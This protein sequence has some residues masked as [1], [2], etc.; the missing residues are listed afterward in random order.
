LGDL[1]QVH[2]TIHLK[3]ASQCDVVALRSCMTSA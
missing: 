2:E 3:G 1:R